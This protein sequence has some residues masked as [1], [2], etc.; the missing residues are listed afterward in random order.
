M[1]TNKKLLTIGS[2]AAV[3]LLGMSIP[4]GAAT[5]KIPNTQAHATA[6]SHVAK[7]KKVKFVGHY[8]GK[9]GL[10]MVGTSG[11]PATSVRVT[12]ITG[13]G[14]GTLLGKS[15]V[16]GT[17]SAPATA[18]NDAITGKGALSGGGS[19]IML[20]AVT[21]KSEGYAAGEAAPTSVTVSGVAKVTGGTGKYKGA[22]GNLTFK[23]SFSVQSNNAGS[24]E[25]DAF[26]ATITGTLT[27]KK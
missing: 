20:T 14:T 19:K 10:L 13:T 7:T 26:T 4:S 22:T 3:A 24:S 15:T 12:S 21:S 9:L 25:S 2:V 16:S 6:V 11:S 17:G 18:Q 1:N 5:S 23:G 27:V 8:T